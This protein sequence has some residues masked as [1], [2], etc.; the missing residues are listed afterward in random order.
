MLRY[1]TSFKNRHYAG[2]Q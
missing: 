1:K 2:R